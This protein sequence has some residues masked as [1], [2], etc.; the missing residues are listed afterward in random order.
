MEQAERHFEHLLDQ[1]S[2]WEAQKQIKELNYEIATHLVVNQGD[3][4]KQR[5]SLAASKRWMSEEGYREAVENLKYHERIAELCKS[6]IEALGGA[7][8]PSLF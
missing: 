1:I 4:R 3:F 7:V 2:G 5:R 6:R 8:S